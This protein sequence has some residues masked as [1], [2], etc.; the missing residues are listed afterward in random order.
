M[1]CAYM[2]LAFFFLSCDYNPAIPI[3]SS[4][5][6]YDLPYLQNFTKLRLTF[7]ANMLQHSFIKQGTKDPGVAQDIWLPREIIFE[8]EDTLY[9]IVW[10]DSTFQ[11]KACVTYAQIDPFF[12][13][14]YRCSNHSYVRGIYHSANKT[15]SDLT[16]NFE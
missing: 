4:G 13:I 5:S 11:T 6:G 9:T 14:S 10:N 16:C 2:L 7:S 15:V 1:R 12:G 3:G 8:N